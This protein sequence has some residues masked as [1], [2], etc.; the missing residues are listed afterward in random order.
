ML[1][2]A[3]QRLS[4]YSGRV[5]LVEKSFDAPLPS[6][7]AVVAS[8]SLHHVNN[9]QSKTKLYSNIYKALGPPG[10]FLNGDC[11][12]TPGQK[13]KEPQPTMFGQNS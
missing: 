8:L 5:L 3:K 11:D 2:A 4:K 12:D 10:I 9:L 7:N 1:A 6:C 13:P